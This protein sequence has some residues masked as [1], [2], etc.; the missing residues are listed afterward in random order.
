MTFGAEPGAFEVFVGDDAT[1]RLSG[2][3]TLAG[4]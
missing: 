2:S 1:A 4:K 3:F